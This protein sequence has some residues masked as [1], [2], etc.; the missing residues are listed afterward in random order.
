MRMAY[1]MPKSLKSFRASPA[2]A[3]AKTVEAFACHAPS[4]QDT[5]I[6]NAT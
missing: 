3:P 4:P 2:G 6:L 1:A 5:D